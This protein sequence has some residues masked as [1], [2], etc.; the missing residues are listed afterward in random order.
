[1][2]DWVKILTW[3]ANGDGINTFDN[4]LISNCFIRTQDDGNYVNGHRISNL[5]MW[6]GCQRSLPCG[7]RSLPNLTSRTLVVENIDLI[8]ARHRWWSGSSALQLPESGGNRGSG[9][10]FSNLNFSDP[11]PSSPAI[12]IH[13]GTNGAF[14]GALFK[15]VTIAD[16]K[17]NNPQ[18]P[19]GRL[20]P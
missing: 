20:H 8:Y 14:A 18:Q 11:F 12:N 2:V 3:R 15:D 1:M 5:V 13:Q 9:V 16:T 4:G 19:A 17:K 6:V 10:I 7:S